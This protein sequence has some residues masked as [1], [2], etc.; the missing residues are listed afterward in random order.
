MVR[1]LWNPKAHYRVHKSPL[2][3]LVLS[4]MDPIHIP[5]Y[6]DG[7]GSRKIGLFCPIDVAGSPRS[8]Y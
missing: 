2:P 1:L 8:F 6:G 7:S 4:Q 5:D 3:D